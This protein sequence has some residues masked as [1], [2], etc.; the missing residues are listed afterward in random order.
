MK[1]LN[2]RTMLRGMAF[3]SAVVVGLPLLEIMEQ[4][5]Q[6]SAA[7]K[8]VRL[9]TWF[10]GNGVN[11]ARW[12]P[13]GATTP[14][15]G[16]AYPLPDHLTH[17]ADLQDYLTVPTGYRNNCAQKI[18]HHEGMSLFSGFTFNNTCFPGQ[19]CQGFFSN[20]G[21]PTIDQVAADVIGVET[22]V[23]SLQLGVSKRIS[24]AD[25]GTTMH[26]LSHRGPQEPLFPERNPVLAYDRLFGNFTPPEDPSKPVR[27]SALNAVHEQA[28]RLQARVGTRDKQRLEAHLDG[29]SELEAKINT[30]PPQ[31]E[32]PPSP[33]N[34]NADVQGVE[35]LQIVNEIM[36]D[37]VAYSFT[38]DVTRVVSILFHEGASDTVFPGT[39]NSGHHNYSH[40]FSVSNGQ[41][42]DQGGLV[43]FNAGMHFT[44]SSF[45]YFLRKLK[46]TPDGVNGNLLDNVAVLAGSDCM[47][48]ISHDFDSEQNLACLIAGR[49][50]GRLLHPGIHLL[51]N[52]RNITDLT[53][54][55]LKA[56]VPE[57][58]SIGNVGSDPAASNTVVDTLLVG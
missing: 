27:L 31:C 32:P 36:S 57:V 35:Q 15:T 34:T 48:G 1:T 2:R 7:G 5:K 4:P 42:V 50:G 17:F 6:A 29:L 14:V 13:G 39:G 22:P 33:T 44:M 23:K 8:P 51:E 58:N 24:G 53:L 18:T 41:E 49:A 38:C 26:A 52:Q 12:I 21:G 40:G 46:D 45:A 11:R 43:G 56:V 47:D 10:W 25:F 19:E 55:V 3:G 37:L 30:L 54:T 20:A 28:K 9:V 16:P